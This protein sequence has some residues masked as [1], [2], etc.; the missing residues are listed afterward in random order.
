MSSQT[1][2]NKVDVEEEKRK[3]ELGGNRESAVNR[4]GIDR[5]N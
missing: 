5:A 1:D 3:E 4:E 2:E